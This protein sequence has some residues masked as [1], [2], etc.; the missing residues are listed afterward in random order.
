MDETTLDELEQKRQAAAAMGGEAALDRLRTAGKLNA[1][2]RLEL[3]LDPGS[4]REVGLL[5]RSQ[6]PDL[7]DRTPAD[8][9]VAGSGKINGRLIYVTSEDASVLAGT[10]GKVAETKAARVRELAFEHRKPFVALM[11]AGAG[12]FQ[13]SSGA[14]A[15]A[16]GLRFRDH[17]RLSG[18]VPQVAALMG[19]CFGGPSFTAAQSDFITIT[20]GTGFMGLSGPAVVKVGT[21]LEATSE[22]IGGS[23]KV[24]TERGLA[25]H[26]GDSEQECLQSI[27]DFLSYFP[28]SSDELP[29]SVDAQP[30]PVDTP[31]GVREITALVSDN[32]RRAYDMRRLVTL[33]VDG[34]HFM[35]YKGLY[36]PNLITGWARL[37]GHSV[38]IIANNPM[39]MAGALDEKATI[40][41]R[42]FIDI[43]NAFHIPIVSL[44]DCPGFLVGPP[45]ENQRMVALASQLLTAIISATTPKVTVV[46]RKAVGLAYIALGGR[47]TSP[48]CLVAWPTARFDVMGTAAG[49]E[50]AYGKEIARADDP[51]KR[52]A[53]MLAAAEE[54]SSTYR[55]AEMALIDDVIHP[56]ETRRVLIEALS[57]ARGRIKPGFKASIMP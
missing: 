4:F 52:R 39:Q 2:E 45:A 19:A 28:E 25:D 53:E 55:A 29:P 54:R 31:E 7:R 49:V 21:G 34:G 43:C 9:M 14:I 5:G 33:I 56:A 23:V 8:G 20:K 11:E 47:A 26:L 42:R 38:G 16:M 15:A 46:L 3:L 48:D 36:G 51:A 13:E 6:H 30:A 35:P 57:R 17:H 41:A 22:E 18:A 10:H 40:K 44:M 12:R 50:L 1:R 27:R 24:C 37:D 32:H